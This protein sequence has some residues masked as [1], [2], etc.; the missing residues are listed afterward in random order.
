[1]GLINQFEFPPAPCLPQWNL[2][3]LDRLSM[4]DLNDYAGY[5]Y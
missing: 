5:V 2:E 4:A 3:L 1:M